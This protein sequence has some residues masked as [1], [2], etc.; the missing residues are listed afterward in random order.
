MKILIATQKPFANK[1]INQMKQKIEESSN[2]MILFEN[3]TSQSDLVE[4]VGPCD[5]MIIRSDK[6]TKEVI[7][8]AKNMKIIVRAGAG[9]DNVDLDAANKQNI[10]VMNTPGQNSNAVAELA[11]GLMIYATRNLF[12][13]SSGSELLGKKLGV[14]AYGNISSNLCKKAKA[15]G[16]EVYAH[17]RTRKRTEADGVKYIKDASELYSFCD[18]VSLHLPKNKTTE[19]SINYTLLSRMREKTVL[20]NT[21]RAELINEEDLLKI[22]TEKPK[23]KYMSD[24][25]PKRVKEFKEKFSERFFSPPKKMGAQTAEANI[26]AG[27]AAVEQINRFFAYDDTT[28]KVNEV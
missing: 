23:F 26:N 14:H 2:K 11:L 15:L 13:G 3:Y 9:Y 4:A 21:A 28:F 17:S 12:D 20:I 19:K 5:A 6:I 24:V 18:F 8:K 27:I 22:M 25:A 16:M 7:E 1:A 10:V